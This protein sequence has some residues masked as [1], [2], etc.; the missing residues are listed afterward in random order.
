MAAAQLDVKQAAAHFCA[1]FKVQCDDVHSQLSQSTSDRNA[2]LVRIS[3]LGKDLTAATVYL[4]AYDQRQCA[5]L[6]KS[7]QDQVTSTN[8][9]RA[10][11]SFASRKEKVNV[12]AATTASL[13]APEPEKQAAGPPTNEAPAQNALHNSTSPRHHRISSKHSTYL[14]P[15]APASPSSPAEDIDISNVTDSCVSLLRL[16]VGALHASHLRNCVV[17]VG[18]IAGSVLIESCENCIFIIACRQLRIHNTT[19]TTF[20]LQITS[21]PILETSNT[22]RFA[23]YP[24]S[25]LSSAFPSSI[26]P[27]AYAR[28]S[29][30]PNPTTS[31]HAHVEDFNWLKRGAQSPNWTL[32]K[33][34][35]EGD[36][37]RVEKVM[38]ALKGWE[39]NEETDIPSGTVCALIQGI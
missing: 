11:F 21:H 33:E 19:H 20:H 9:P 36:K 8:P 12:V 29:I 17:V 24:V 39:A 37:G 2:A 30:D 26:L 5:A 28:A 15:P 18:P 31:L 34:D 38:R 23:P 13:S 14:S 35:E 1:D 7:L 25:S 22:L 6:L 4:P 16:S 10:K 32:V 27:A 3:A